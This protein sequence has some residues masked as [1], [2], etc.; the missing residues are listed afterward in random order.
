MA[1]QIDL[2]TGPPAA[3]PP[4]TGPSMTVPS[5][6]MSST[7]TTTSSSSVLR[8][9][10]SMTV[11]GRR[12]PGA[13]NPPRNVAISSS[14]RCVADRPMRWGGVAQRASSRSSVNARC[15]PRLVAARAWISSMITASTLTSVSRAAE[16]SI[17]YSDSGVVMSRSGGWRARRRRSSAGVSPVREPTVGTCTGWPARSAAWAMPTSG[18][19]RF[20]STSTARARSGETYRRRVAAF[21]S[22]GGVVSSRSIPHRNAARVFPEPVGARIS[23]CSPEAMAGHPCSWAVV[24]AGNEEANQSRTGDEK[25]SSA[26]MPAAYGRPLTA[27]PSGARQLPGRPQLSRSASRA[28]NSASDWPVLKD[29]TS[30]ASARSRSRFSAVHAC[31]SS[32]IPMVSDAASS[33]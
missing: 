6:P 18:A 16:V 9:P 8:I 32:A 10:A 26:A 29:F 1:G 23:V 24:G 3:G 25:R 22:G 13:S 7:G 21:G 5:A 30:S 17:R 20:F 31:T 33:A 15:D 28:S 27:G 2:L 12:L 11:T 4:P 14:G 19:R